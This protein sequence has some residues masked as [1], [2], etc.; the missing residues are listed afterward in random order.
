MEMQ[1][2]VWGDLVEVFKTNKSI[3][4]IIHQSTFG[5]S[6][7]SGESNGRLPDLMG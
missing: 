2:I 4:I 5:K 7:G 1:C 6:C 3:V